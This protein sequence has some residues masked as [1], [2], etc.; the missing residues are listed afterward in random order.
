MGGQV[1]AFPRPG[2]AHTRQDFFPHRGEATGAHLY[3]TKEG[4]VVKLR[5]PV[6]SRARRRRKQYHSSITRDRAS[7]KKSLV[8]KKERKGKGR[9]IE[10]YWVQLELIIH[11]SN[12]PERSIPA[13]SSIHQEPLGNIRWWPV[14]AGPS[15][16]PPEETGVVLV[17]AQRKW[18]IEIEY[19]EKE[20]SSRL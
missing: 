16:F 8:T 7:K 20:S 6:S 18:P 11:H 19:V 4:R 3:Q 17:F 10:E 12:N 5:V 14:S 2:K 13:E 9:L 1:L 15:L